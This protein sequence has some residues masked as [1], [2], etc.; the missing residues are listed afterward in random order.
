MITVYKILLL[1]GTFRHCYCV[2][3]IKKIYGF[4]EIGGDICLYLTVYKWTMNNED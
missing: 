1:V 3:R 2:L 4:V